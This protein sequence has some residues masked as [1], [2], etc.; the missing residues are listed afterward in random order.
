MPLL[1]DPVTL[2]EIADRLGVARQTAKQ[3]RLRKV[4]PPPKWTPAGAPLW[5][6]ADVRRWA[7]KTGR[8]T[9]E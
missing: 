8:L 4:L 5:E 7:I 3:W 1:A 9:D 6:W 2:A